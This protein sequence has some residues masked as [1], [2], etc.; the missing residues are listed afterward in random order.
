MQ[1]N[2]HKMV[3]PRIKLSF[4]AEDGE[5]EEFLGLL[6][7]GS[8]L[9]DEM[10]LFEPRVT[11]TPQFFDKIIKVKNLMFSFTYHVK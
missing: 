11:F 9:L 4:E 1:K 10:Y 5:S 8:K 6:L 7:R 2:I 3:Y